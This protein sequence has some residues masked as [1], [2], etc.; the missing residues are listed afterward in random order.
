MT[1]MI[2]LVATTSVNTQFPINFGWLTDYLEQ[3]YK[4]ILLL[5]EL[6]ENASLV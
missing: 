3:N 2:C 1:N 4:F 6:C 5:F